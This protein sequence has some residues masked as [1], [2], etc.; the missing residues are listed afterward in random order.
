MTLPPI[1]LRSGWD[2]VPSC[3]SSDQAANQKPASAAA[4]AVRPYYI[5][6]R[7]RTDGDRLIIFLD[8]EASSLGKRGFPIE[9]GWAAEDGTEMGCLI[10][11]APGWDEWSTDAEQVHGIAWDR[12]VRDGE[13]H[14]A[15]AA[16]M[17]QALS[18]HDLYASAPSWDG[19]WLSRL[20]RAAGLPRHALRLGNTKAVQV[21]TA[22]AILEDVGGMPAA[23]R[24]MLVAEILDG[25][26]RAFAEVAPAH[27]ALED[28]RRELRLWQDVRERAE[29][30][31]ARA[32]RI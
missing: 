21:K 17:V 32:G 11:P 7:R 23:L 26:R 20:L 14:E 22:T 25:S 3:F 13:P 16:G 31:A 27:R 8:F 24:N 1:Q 18:G 28:A 30:A 2:R 4:P 19:Q 5:S 10:R 29:A 15:V 6:G 12:L 9:V